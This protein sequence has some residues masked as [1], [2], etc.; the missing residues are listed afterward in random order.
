MSTLTKR[1]LLIAAIVVV[2]F[3]FLKTKR[4]FKRRRTKVTPVI[5]RRRSTG[6]VFVP[7]SRGKRKGRG[8]LI[9]LGNR[10]LTPKQWGLAM[11]RRRKK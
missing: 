8:K 7:R 4:R 10:M 3:M 2:F 11:K 6:S 5:R 1:L 9:R